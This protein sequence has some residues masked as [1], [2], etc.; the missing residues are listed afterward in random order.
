[1]EKPKGPGDCAACA[2][3]VRH[4]LRDR[5][6]TDCA[7]HP[8]VERIVRSAVDAVVGYIRARATSEQ[9][10]ADRTDYPPAALQKQM[11]AEV[12]LDVAERIEKG[13]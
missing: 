4:V 1:M 9:V 3:V 11:A 10:N 7:F 8:G 13:G 6:G 5:D 12:L 2:K